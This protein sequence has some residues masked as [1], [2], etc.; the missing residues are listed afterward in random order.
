MKLHDLIALVNFEDVSKALMEAY[1]YKTTDSYEKVFSELLTMEPKPLDDNMRII[2]E[3]VEPDPR[4]D[5]E[6][7]WHVHGK[8]GKKFKDEEPPELLKGCDEEF[9]NSEVG[10][11]LDFTS[12]GEWLSME[13]DEIS[14]EK[15]SKPEVCA[16]ILWEMTF[17]G[18]EEKPIQERKDSLMEQVENIKNGKSGEL[19]DMDDFKSLLDEVID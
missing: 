6:G 3:W 1:D 15:L 7:Y 9:L 12:W 5:E 4:F 16:Y 13:I 17:H 18:F 10:Y 19:V 11:A 8:N 14:F 2:V